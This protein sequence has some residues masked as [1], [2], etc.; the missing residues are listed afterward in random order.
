MEDKEGASYQVFTTLS[1]YRG[2]FTTL[3]GCRW[4]TGVGEVIGSTIPVGSEGKMVRTISSTAPCLAVVAVQV[5][6]L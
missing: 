5:C 1:G 2:L 3:S 4:S 6:I